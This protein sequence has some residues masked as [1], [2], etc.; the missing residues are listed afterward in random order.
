MVLTVKLIISERLRQKLTRQMLEMEGGVMASPCQA[1]LSNANP[2]RF[3]CADA[4]P[5]NMRDIYW[6]AAM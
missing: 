2:I 6:H 3:G 1:A 5:A 4:L